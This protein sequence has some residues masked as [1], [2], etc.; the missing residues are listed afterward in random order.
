MSE[1]ILVDFKKIKKMT[2]DLSDDCDVNKLYAN[3]HNKLTLVYNETL[4]L[5]LKNK[6]NYIRISI[7]H[8]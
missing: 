8:G 5:K 4:P 3:F 1:S 6:S 7:N 2:W